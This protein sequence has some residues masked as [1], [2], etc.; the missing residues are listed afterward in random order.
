MLPLLLSYLTGRKFRI[1]MEIHF[2]EWKPIRAGVPQGPVLASLLYSVYVADIPRRSEIEVSQFPDDIATC[3]LDI[4]INYA[5]SNLHRYMSEL[6]AWLCK[7]KRE[8]NADEN[9]TEIFTKRRQMPRHRLNTSKK[10][11]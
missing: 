9:T 1:R 11:F 5:I 8:T 2:S 7:W 3:T 10:N 4:N 6:E